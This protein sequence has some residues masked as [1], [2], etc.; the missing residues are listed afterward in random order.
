MARPRSWP[1]RV[2]RHAS[3]QAR[4]KIDGKDHYLGL[5]GSEEAQRRYADLLARHA[6][7]EPL[8][9]PPAQSPPR[10]TAAGPTV[11]EVCERWLAED[12]P[13]YAEGGREVTQFR[14]SLK[15][16]LRLYGDTPARDFDTDR[17]ERVQL[18]MA[19]GDWMTAAEKAAPRGPGGH[20]GLARSVVNRRVVRI[21]TVWRWAE[22]K[23]LVPPGSFAHLCSLPGLGKTDARVRHTPKVRP[24]TMA[25]VNAV[26]KHLPPVGRALLLVQW[27]GGMRSQEVREMRAGE[28]DRS[29]EPW[30]YRP[31]RN[32]MDR[33]GQPRVV[34]LGPRARAVLRPWLE[35]KAPGD[36]VFPPTA[37]RAG[38]GHYSRSSYAQ[39]V[40]RA[41]LAAGL[42]GWHAYRTRHG[43]KQRLTRA[44]GLDAARAALGQ[45]SLGVTNSYGDALDMDLA[46]RAAERAG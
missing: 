42:P 25:E 13:R 31:A 12:A 14:L 35:G 3:G 23:K 43:A 24:A 44:L 45:R 20:V 33:S 46:A 40:R 39:L 32:K 21:R 38:R 19:S 1:P 18:S 8:D 6:R 9:G 27:W 26:C 37:D 11:A 17:L 34:V 15:P 36:F 16:L 5:Y 4:V 2:T 28:V 41:A 29:A 30:V 10:V 22:R 7:G